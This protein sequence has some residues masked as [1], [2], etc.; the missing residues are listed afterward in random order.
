[1]VDWLDTD[2]SVH[3]GSL[4][5]PFRVPFG[6]L[7]VSSGTYRAPKWPNTVPMTPVTAV[8]DSIFFAPPRPLATVEANSILFDLRKERDDEFY[9][10]LAEAAGVSEAVPIDDRAKLWFPRA[11]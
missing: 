4:R 2:K 5:V 10:M 6:S 11:A 7:A 9:L 1:M 8:S 3:F